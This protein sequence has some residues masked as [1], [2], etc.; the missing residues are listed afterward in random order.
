MRPPGFHYSQQFRCGQFLIRGE[1]HAERGQRDVETA[2]VERQCLG[3]GHLEFDRQPVAGRTLAPL[4]QQL[5]NV[6]GRG[7]LRESACGR[8]RGIA[9]SGRDVENRLGGAHVDGF[10]KRFADD[11]QGRTDDAEVAGS[12]G[13]LLASLDCGQVGGGR[14]YRFRVGSADLGAEHGEFSVDQRFGSVCFV[15]RC[16]GNRVWRRTNCGDYVRPTPVR[17]SARLDRES[18]LAACLDRNSAALDR[19]PGARVASESGQ[20]S[21]CQRAWNRP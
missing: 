1:H 8:E 14:G 6:V 20:R 2:L 16:R 3:I 18:G 15:A 12:P 10:A 7:Y 19:R 5:G 9:V 21:P 4:L 17:T 13:R 11:L